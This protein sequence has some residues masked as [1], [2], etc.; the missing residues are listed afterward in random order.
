MRHLYDKKRLIYHKQTSTTVNMQGIRAATTKWHNY[1]VNKKTNFEAIRC[2][3]L[4]QLR[5]SM[6]GKYKILHIN[7]PH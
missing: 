6:F 1:I 2:D 5:N 4:M 3:Y 7:T